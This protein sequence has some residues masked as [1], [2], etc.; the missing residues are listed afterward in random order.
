MIERSGTTSA[1]IVAAMSSSPWPA[2][3]AALHLLARSRAR[4]ASSSPAPRRP[5]A[6]SRA[7]LAASASGKLGLEVALD[8][9]LALE[10]RVGRA[11]RAAVDHLEERSRVDAERPRPAR[12]SPPGPRSSASTHVLRTSF[13]RV[14]A[15]ASP[16]HDGLRADRVEHGS[17]SARARPRGRRR[18]RSACPPRRAAGAEHRRVDERHAGALARRARRSVASSPTV[19]IC[20]QTAPSSRQRPPTTASTASPSAS[21]VTTTSAPSTASAALAG[22][23]APSAAS[24]S[25][26]LA[27]CGSRRAP[28]GRPRRGCAPSARP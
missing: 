16:S 1:W 22:Q 8:H 10:L 11:D 21:I 18:A 5:R 13:S 23:L 4:A 6:T 28:R 26:L 12:S 2:S 14:P 19:L 27:R 7:S 24:P 25:R 9:Q 20:A 15:P 3:T 17:R